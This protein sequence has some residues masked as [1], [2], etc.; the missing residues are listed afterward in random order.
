M[1]N[2]SLAAV[3]CHDMQV[4]VECS[5]DTEAWWAPAQE[6]VDYLHDA[7]ARKRAVGGGDAAATAATSLRCFYAY[8]RY[9][10]S[11]RDTLAEANV[12]DL[13][14]LTNIVY[15]A[16]FGSRVWALIHH[17]TIDTTSLPGMGYLEV[18][19]GMNEAELLY[20]LPDIHKRCQKALQDLPPVP[21]S[22]LYY[23]SEALDPVSQLHM[24]V[25]ACIEQPEDRVVQSQLVE[26]AVDWCS[27]MV[28]EPHILGEF[29]LGLAKLSK[30]PI[31][32]RVLSM[33]HLFGVLGGAYPHGSEAANFVYQLSEVV[34]QYSET[35]EL[36]HNGAGDASMRFASWR[37][38]VHGLYNDLAI[39]PMDAGEGFETPSTRIKEASQ[40][41]NLSTIFNY[42]FTLLDVISVSSDLATTE[43]K[44]LEWDA[45]L[46][47]IVGYLQPDMGL[48]SLQSW[49]CGENN[50]FKQL[51]MGEAEVDA[52]PAEQKL[53]IQALRGD[54][55]EV[56]TEL[57]VFK[58][59]GFT[60]HL[61]DTLSDICIGDSTVTSDLIDRSLSSYAA[62]LYHKSPGSW[63]ISLD[64][65]FWAGGCEG[66]STFLNI[67]QS[68]E[69]NSEGLEHIISAYQMWKPTDTDGSISKMI[70]NTIKRHG[71][72]LLLQGKVVEGVRR[73]M[74]AE[75]YE[76]VEWHLIKLFKNW[77]VGVLTAGG[78]GPDGWAVL[79][80]SSPLLS[81]SE[82]LTSTTLYRWPSEGSIKK[83]SVY[84]STPSSSFLD[85][86]AVSP[87]LAKLAHAY[88][89]RDGESARDAGIAI[90]QEQVSPSILKLAI[91][92]LLVPLMLD[93]SVCYFSTETIGHMASSL[94]CILAEAGY[95][96]SLKSDISSV[97]IEVVRYAI[98][99]AS[100]KAVFFGNQLTG[101]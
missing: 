17:L 21:A 61:L 66:K 52:L 71:H 42:L 4:G 55:V 76:Q 96:P 25:T 78:L 50:I 77:A 10:K 47:V 58:I 29:M 27:M 1:A 69:V 54:V 74:Q 67:L 92:Y 37:S 79:D 15:E 39:V 8:M 40:G 44:V 48:E 80:I 19:R 41:A 86:L 12:E 89:H 100:G 7:M 64:Y 83:S 30:T 98:V 95:T 5:G 93:Q 81:L 23:A 90:L 36:F 88:Q 97:D 38:M 53:L 87:S 24:T 43:P 101:E 60:P 85:I 73:L 59:P 94:E 68:I 32:H 14:P 51:Q 28:A 57:N 3:L 82:A 62:L 13:A 26:I 46:A 75:D 16:E 33:T 6:L 63:R 99:V 45:F 34:R 56:A 9:A 22:V 31:L 84:F 35:M 49:M 2:K 65:C 20:T 70:K 18:Y 91:L 11:M 72:V